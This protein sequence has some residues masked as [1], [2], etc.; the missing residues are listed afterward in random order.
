[1]KS[2]REE[3]L[4]VMATASRAL[5]KI[6]SRYSDISTHQ[7]DQTNED[8]NLLDM[9]YTM[10]QS[11]PEGMPKAMLRLEIQQKI[12]QLKIGFQGV[13]NNMQWT[14]NYSNN[15][16]PPTAPHASL[17]SSVSTDSPSSPGMN[18]NNLYHPYRH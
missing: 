6:E 9:V 14:S 16:V 8:K 2:Q 5:E 17:Q 7:N 18:F 3:K 1:M 13:G 10:L 4:D 12:I 15:F 11:I